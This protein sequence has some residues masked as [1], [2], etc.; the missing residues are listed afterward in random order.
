TPE[1]TRAVVE[2]ELP[3]V[4]D[5]I[6]DAGRATTP[7]AALSRATAGV[8]GGT[9]VVNLPGSPDGVRDGLAAL[10]PLREHLHSQLAGGG[11]G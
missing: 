4:A 9:L 11:H 7:M 8:R 3:G 2:F 1:A 10:D 6:R 5:A